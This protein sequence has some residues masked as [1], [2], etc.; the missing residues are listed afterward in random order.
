MIEAKKEE[1][2]KIVISDAI[3]KPWAV[4]IHLK[5]A[6]PTDRAMMST[7]WFPISA[8]HTVLFLVIN[9]HLKS[10]TLKIEKYLWNWLRFFP[11]SN[12]IANYVENHHDIK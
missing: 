1:V 8:C 5:D 3:T 4:M 12:K 6:C 2:F 9:C 11:T 10:F 7:F